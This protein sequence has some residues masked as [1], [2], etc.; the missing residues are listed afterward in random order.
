MRIWDLGW[1]KFGSG[2]NIPNPQHGQ[3]QFFAWAIR[4]QQLI[5]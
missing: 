5:D 4:E 2:I 1:K 3:K